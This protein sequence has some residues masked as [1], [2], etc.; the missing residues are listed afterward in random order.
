[1]Y[2]FFA[3]RIAR[4][5]SKSAEKEDKGEILYVKEESMSCGR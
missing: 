4:G 5:E 2:F 3:A 1:L